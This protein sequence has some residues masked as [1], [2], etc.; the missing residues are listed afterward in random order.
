[1]KR[2]FSIYTTGVKTAVAESMAYRLNFLLSMIIALCSNLLFPLVTIL[3]YSA[4]ASFPGW[5]LYEML[6]LQ[7]IF[8]T[9][10]GLSYLLWEGM[11]YSTMFRVV[12]GTF[13]VVLLKP[14]SPLFYLV[15]SSFNPQSFG[16]VIGGSVLFGFALSQTG[17]ASAMAAA[18]F[19]LF[20][21][22]GFFVLSGINMM[23]AAMS[24]KWV[25]NTRITEIFNSVLNFGKYPAGIFPTAVRGVTTFIIPV[26]MIGF[27]PASALLGRLPPEA[28]LAIIPCVLFMLFGVWVYKLMV[29]KYEGVGG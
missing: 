27:F 3:I 28:Y 29:R 25:R 4:G 2:I 13:E 15:V 18:Q 22:A 10:G 21:A 14:L 26:M 1:M 20:F 8:I 19:L 9:S 12:D 17:V 16:T 24:F 23:M 5:N 6:L 11:V 7:S